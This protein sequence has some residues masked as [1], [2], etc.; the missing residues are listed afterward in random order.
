MNAFEK[1]LLDG[2]VLDTE[3]EVKILIQGSLF[4]CLAKH[5]MSKKSGTEMLCSIYDGKTNSAT[6]AQKPYRLNGELHR[7]HLRTNRD[8][9]SHLYKMFDIKEQLKDLEAPVTGL[10][11]IDLLL[12]SLSNQTCYNV[13]RGNVLFSKDM[14]KY[15][16]EGIRELML[17][18]EF[19]SKD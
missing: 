8:I 15:T 1:S 18:A 5:V 4:M 17:T 16:P 6:K 7:I 9:R 14:N 10:Q 3:T 12:R 13:L 19:R 2:I 11:M